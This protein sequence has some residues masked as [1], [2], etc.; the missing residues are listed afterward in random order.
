[1]FLAADFADQRADR[2]YSSIFIYRC[3]SDK[4]VARLIQLQTNAATLKLPP[5]SEILLSLIRICVYLRDLWLKVFLCPVP[6]ALERFVQVLHGVVNAA[7]HIAF[8]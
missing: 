6:N 3:N 8:T 7:A 1:Y 4:H 5:A 2:N